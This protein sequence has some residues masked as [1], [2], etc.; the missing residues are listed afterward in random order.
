MKYI[1]FNNH[2]LSKLSLGT[3]QFGIDYGIAN[4]NGKPNQ[5]KINEI[6]KYISSSGINSYDTAQGYGESEK[7]LGNY[8][9]TLDTSR[10]INIVSKVDSKELLLTIENFVNNVLSSL[11]KLKVDSLFGLLMHNSHLM[12]QWNDE[13]SNKINILKEKNMVR[14]FGVSI[15]SDNEFEMA[16]D[17]TN[18]DIIQIPF[19]IFDQRAITNKWF[20]K[21]KEKN[22]LIFIRSIYLQGLLL[23]N[24]DNIPEKLNKAKEYIVSLDMLCAKLAI[25][26]NELCLSF[27]NTVAKESSLLFG[28]ETISQAQDNINTFDNMTDID[29][30]IIEKIMND[31]GEIPEVIYNPTKW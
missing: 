31:F 8:F 5:A 29:T 20:E 23:M 4:K 14:Y 15:Y 28:C 22:K 6:L 19:S 27:V 2:K 18:I 3:V 17:N 26:R 30:E 7:V 13:Y 16:L 25:T 9:S 10:N 21:A 24:V 11:D 12:A 1:K